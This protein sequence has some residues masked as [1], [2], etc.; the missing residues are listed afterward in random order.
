MLFAVLGLAGIS[1]DKRDSDPELD[2]RIKNQLTDGFCI[3]FGDSILINHKDIEY[4]DYSTHFIYLKEIHPIF[5]D[6]FDLEV[7]NMSFSVYAHRE[8]IY[9][10][11]IFPAWLSSMPSGPYIQWPSFYPGDLI[12]ID[13]MPPPGN[14]QPDT[15]EDPRN[16]QRIVDALQEH[17]QYHHGLFMELGSIQFNTGGGVSFTYTLTNNDSFDYYVLSPERMGL[18]L[19][20]YFTNGLYLYNQETGWLQHQIDVEAPEPWDSWDTSWLDRL[21]HKTSRS[22]EVSYDEFD[23]VPPGTYSM[24]FRFPGLSHVEKDDRNLSGGLIWMGELEFSSEVTLN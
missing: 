16:D 6:P 7:A 17:D 3:S 21:Y 20:H 12:K 23:Q 22:Y 8:K 14:L 15:L 24:Y 19:F 11:T 4:Y 1:C 10:G 13:Y 9:S 2:A 5:E 18:G